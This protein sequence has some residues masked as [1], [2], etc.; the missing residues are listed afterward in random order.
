MFNID[1]AHYSKTAR[2]AYMMKPVR[3]NFE[4]ALIRGALTRQI[5]VLGTC[6]MQE[7]LSAGA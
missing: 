3:T 6:R 7:L 2:K 4:R 1:P 5:Q